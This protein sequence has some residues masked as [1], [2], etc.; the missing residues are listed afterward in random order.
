MLLK[1][2]IKFSGGFQ[3][4]FGKEGDLTIMYSTNKT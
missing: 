1:Y 2:K 4:I 3:Y